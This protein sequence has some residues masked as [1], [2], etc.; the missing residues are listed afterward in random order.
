MKSKLKGVK[1]LLI[2]VAAHITANAQIFNV[3]DFGAVGDG[4][5]VNT[6][7]IQK[8]IDKCS[9]SGGQVL[10]PPGIFV[11]GTLYLKSKVNL[12]V[13]ANGVLKGSPSFTDYPSNEVK[14]KNAFTHYADGKSYDNKA[15][16]FAERVSNISFT[17][18]GTIDGN[19]DSAEFQLGDDN[20]EK[21]RSRPCMLLI[22]DSKNISLSDLHLTNS[23]YWLQNYLGC[24]NLKLQR[25][26]IFNQSNYNQDGI[27]IDAKNVLIE[28]CVIDVDDDG[29]CFKSHDRNRMVG[30]AVVR[31]CTISS[32]CNAIKFGTTSIGGLKNVSI[33]NCTIKKASADHIRNWQKNL[34]FIEQPITV[35]SGIAL[36][37]VDGGII[38][39]IRISNIR[40]TD[41]QTPI[42]IVL[43]NRDRK[44]VGDNA[45][46]IG[47]IENISIRNI[48]AVSHS[49][50]SSS[51]TAYPGQY[52]K[53]VKLENISISSMGKGTK[54]EANLNLPENSK[55]Y[56]EN[57]MYGQV[58]P[59]SGFFIRHVNGLSFE[60]LELKT[61]STDF[62]P[63]I[64]MDDVN[65]CRLN[66]LKVTPYPTVQPVIKIVGCKEISISKASPSLKS[67]DVIKLVNTSKGE[68]KV[69]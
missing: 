39:D 40:M 34:K 29:I 12:H 67:T 31:N 9:E 14:Y 17:G 54:A 49:K 8:A 56:P 52:I 24:E 44:Q 32:N 5:T 55:D 4:K 11:S 68:V 16:I 27:D 13:E 15:F 10:I 18:T 65:N 66:N 60:G 48:Y 42:F 53:N 64:I 19:G 43:G 2:L 3:K 6:V 20:N 45:S 33:E 1:V 30:N 69:Y 41:V 23:A 37:S 59:A 36:E 46:P 62:R 28:D 61:R 51:I 38:E 26:K 25:L 58:Y 22:I 21:S 7:A 35:I 57:R 47:K 63:A 50:M